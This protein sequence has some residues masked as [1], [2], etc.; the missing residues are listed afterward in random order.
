MSA[1]G[2]L[3]LSDVFHQSLL[4]DESIKPLRLNV[5]RF[6]RRRNTVSWSGCKLI[7]LRNG[8]DWRLHKSFFAASLVAWRV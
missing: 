1:A 4:R 2:G 6:T 7:R 8:D 3:D 5:S